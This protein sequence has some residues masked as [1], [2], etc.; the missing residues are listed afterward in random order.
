MVNPIFENR[1][2]VRKY[3]KEAISDDKIQEMIAAFQTA[4]CGMHQADVMNLV[5]VKDKGLRNKIEEVTDNSCYNA[6]VLFLIN[7]KKDS[8]FG[9]RDA[10]VAAENIMLEATDLSLGSIYIMGGAAR[11]NDFSDL[12]QELGI[13]P[14]FQTTVIVAVGKSAVEPEKE[15]RSKRYHVTIY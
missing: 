9:E 5:V 10:S 6:P 15:D 14:E 8:E 1:R 12:Q 2:A 7:T 11:L 3:S 4:P 13:D